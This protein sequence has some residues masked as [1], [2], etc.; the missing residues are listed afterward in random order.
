M[1]SLARL[2]KPI[3]LQVIPIATLWPTH[4][5]LA[6]SPPIENT[7]QETGYITGDAATHRSATLNL[8]IAAQS[9]LY[10]NFDLQSTRPQNSQNWGQDPL[11]ELSDDTTGGA[12]LYSQL[13]LAL[14]ARPGLT[15]ILQPALLRYWGQNRQAYTE[16]APIDHNHRYAATLGAL[17]V[18]HTF[19]PFT[20]T[21][22][23]QPHSLAFT[24]PPLSGAKEADYFFYATIEGWRLDYYNP[25]LGL[26]SALASIRSAPPGN[27][28]PYAAQ[29]ADTIDMPP[30]IF[31]EEGEERQTERQEELST[32]LGYN[33]RGDL[34]LITA[35][36]SYEAPQTLLGKS[37]YQSLAFVYL[38]RYGATL[39]GRERASQNP[40]RPDRDYHILAGAKLRYTRGPLQALLQTA[41][42]DGIDRKLPTNSGYSRDILTRGEMAALSL[43]YS[44]TPKAALGYTIHTE[45][46]ATYIEGPSFDNYGN[47]TSSGFTSIS[48]QSAGG[49]LLRGVADLKPCAYGAPTAIYVSP[50]FSNFASGAN[51][52]YYGFSYRGEVF[53]AAFEAWL[54][55]DNSQNHYQNSLDREPGGPI[56][57]EPS[58]NLLSKKMVG[59]EFN[60]SFAM[61]APSIR[62]LVTLAAFLPGEYLSPLKD[63]FT[64][65]FF[66]TSFRY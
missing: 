47:M 48:P 18:S 56:I 24:Q 49:A 11:T 31:A 8:D 17:A 14:Q 34:P 60:L 4:P 12:Y 33:Y 1:K 29:E 5:L 46:A 37:A 9:Y 44:L 26:I 54:F 57:T 42:S 53:E 40:N 16:P 3:F 13:T 21:W 10:D 38:S 66:G 63:P 7:R 43:A 20:L 30:Q 59:N 45:I 2:L 61:R 27:L 65:I 55:F 32:P 15:A 41:A 64:G 36:L 52:L 25:S 50:Q 35:G 28:I 22:G 6:K 62:Y 39:G 58:A 19:S 51:F 23:R